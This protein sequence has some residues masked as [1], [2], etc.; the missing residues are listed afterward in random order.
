MAVR[1]EYHP[2]FAGQYD[3]LADLAQTSDA[4]WSC[5]RRSLR[6]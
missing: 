3:A 2:R 1:V 4:Q 6:W 5:S